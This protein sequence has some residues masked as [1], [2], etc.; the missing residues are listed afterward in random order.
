MFPRLFCLAFF[1]L[2]CAALAHADTFPVGTLSFDL[3]QTDSSG[4]LYGL[5][6]FN[7][8]QPG[9]GSPVSTFLSFS[10][11]ALSVTFSAGGTSSVVLTPTD[12]LGDFSTGATFSADQLLSATLTG[13][14]SPTT[15][16]L[17]NANI[18][19]INSAFSTLVTD[20]SGGPLQDG[21]L[22]IINATTTVQST[23]EPSPALLLL[24]GV[25]LCVLSCQIRE[26][27]RGTY[28]RRVS[29]R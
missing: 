8:T 29:S 22:A 5:D 11:L 16:I 18:V 7:G 17:A 19:N 21:D 15:G 2:A 6:V 26:L 3:L 28:E 24:F 23:P 27:K 14:F 10:N 1:I 9:G 25:A 13:T 4:S 12:A 20:I